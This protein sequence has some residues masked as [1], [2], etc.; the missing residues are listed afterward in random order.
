MRHEVGAGRALDRTFAAI[1]TPVVTFAAI[2]VVLGP[3][4]V[5]GQWGDVVLSRLDL[6]GARLPVRA[7]D[8]DPVTV[9]GR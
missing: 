2:A 4:L 6:P 3:P 1:Y 5:D 9:V 8:F 7:G